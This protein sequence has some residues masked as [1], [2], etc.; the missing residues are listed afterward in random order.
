MT[1]WVCV[2]I[3]KDVSMMYVQQSEDIT[4]PSWEPTSHI[5]GDF[6]KRLVEEYLDDDMF[7]EAWSELKNK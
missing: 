1:R 3:E 7:L 5:T 6:L 4:E 2:D